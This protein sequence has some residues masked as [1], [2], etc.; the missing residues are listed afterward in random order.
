VYDKFELGANAFNNTA[1]G[2]LLAASS[3]QP[4]VGTFL[5]FHSFT[6]SFFLLCSFALNPFAPLCYAFLLF[7]F[8]SLRWAFGFLS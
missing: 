8:A 4:I 1:V 2:K 3:P 7:T 6:L 5:S